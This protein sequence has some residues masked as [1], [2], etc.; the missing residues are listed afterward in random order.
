MSKIKCQKENLSETPGI[1]NIPGTS[2][3]SELG[4]KMVNVA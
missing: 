2:D 1:V 4:F 3:F